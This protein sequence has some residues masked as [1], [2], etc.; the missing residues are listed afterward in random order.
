MSRA[1]GIDSR[2]EV[3][4]RPVHLLALVR[5]SEVHLLKVSVGHQV[6]VS[7]RGPNLKG[8]VQLTMDRVHG[9]NLNNIYYLPTLPKVA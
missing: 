7:H 8:P 6:R 1:K 5:N 3:R 2:K 9:T 4:A